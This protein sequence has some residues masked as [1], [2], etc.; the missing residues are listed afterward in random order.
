MIGIYFIN[1]YF[2]KSL[3]ALIASFSFILKGDKMKSSD[4]HNSEYYIAKYIMAK[5]ERNALDEGTLTVE[6]T[7]GYWLYEARPCPLHE[8]T[9]MLEQNN[10]LLS[11][12]SFYASVAEIL[13]SVY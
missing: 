13:K 3:E 7:A 11:Q 6:E 5:V 10:I 8:F 1:K 9:Q 2:A 4:T 12:N